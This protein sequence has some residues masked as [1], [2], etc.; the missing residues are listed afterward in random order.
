MKKI[1]L[2]FTILALVLLMPSCENDGGDSNL[3]LEIGA[4]PNITKVATTDSF[5]NLVNVS[6]GSPINL[7]LTVSVAQGEVSSMDI[8]GFYKKGANLYKAV[9]KSNITTFPVTVNF[10]QTDLISA[11]SELNSINDFAVGD[12]LTIS[13]E[14]KLKNGSVIQMVNNNG[15]PNYGQDIANSIKY[16]VLQTYSVSCPSNLAGTFSYSTTNMGEPGG[17]RVAGPVTGTVKFTT[18]DAGM[19]AISDASFGGWTG[20]YGPGNIAT[21]VKLKDICNKI[22]YSGVDQYNEVFT[23]SNLVV[24]GTKLSFHW[25]NDYGEFGDTT[26]TR[27]DGTN[28]PTLTL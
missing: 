5:I 3:D 14:L 2:I 13:A 22:S 17:G 21:G 19:Y 20:L 8:V 25:E 4:L 6:S 24:N 10:S 27:A 7:G 1:K 12:V 18:A 23:F 26:L 11:F 15:T 16:K 9:L 28:W